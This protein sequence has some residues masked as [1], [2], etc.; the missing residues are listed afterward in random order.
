MEEFIKNN[1]KDMTK[2]ELASKL[3]ITYNQVE[4]IMKKLNLRHYKSIKYTDEEIQFIKNNYPT[5]GSKYCAEK[6]N[7]S[8]NAINKKIKK[9]GL[10]IKWKYLYINKQ[11]YLVNCEDRNNKYE[12]HRKVME[13]YLGR[14]LKSSEIVHHI[15]GNKLNN[16]ISN[17][18]VV[19]R[20][21]H[22][23]IHRKD[24]QKVKY[25]I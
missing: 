10:E 11:G 5:K 23:N 6:L 25:K 1:Y 20:K 16:D 21:E 22:I 13:D 9:L 12:V 8:I 2:K 19:S 14:K 17:L 15:D 24:L 3:G 7:R 4:W 18:V